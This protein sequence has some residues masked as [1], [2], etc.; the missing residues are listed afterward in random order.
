[1]CFEQE[2]PKRKKAKVCLSFRLPFT[3]ICH[4]LP[5]SVADRGVCMGG[6][7][8]R[9]ETE[10][11]GWGPALSLALDKSASEPVSTRAR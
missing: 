10:N 4:R 11:L 7:R 9:T 3:K 2:P 6:G 5:A 8:V 1:M